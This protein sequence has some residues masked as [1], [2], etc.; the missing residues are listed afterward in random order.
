MRPDEMEPYAAR[1][2]YEAG[3]SPVA[4]TALVAGLLEDIGRRCE[5]AGATLVGHIKCHA[6]GEAQRFH[7]NL[8]STRAGASCWD[9]RGVR[10]EGSGQKPCD[11]PVELLLPGAS[12]EVDLVVLVYG[13]TRDAVAVA[14]GE[15]MVQSSR[16]FGG[17]WH[18]RLVPGE[19]QCHRAAGHYHH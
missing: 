19:D 9:A 7:C 17:V 1:F 13:L 6:R 5:E 18:V 2:V 16:V 4:A 12:M 3:A 10:L 11:E 15:A 8:T 14:V